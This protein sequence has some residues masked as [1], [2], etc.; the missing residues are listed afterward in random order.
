MEAPEV[1][2][3]ALSAVRSPW[4]IDIVVGVFVA[5]LNV[6]TT[7]TPDPSA[8]YY[9]YRE[10]H[11]LALVTLTV[12]A[13][14]ALI[15]RRYAP[16]TVLV[17]NLATFV[18]VTALEW[19]AGSLAVGLLVALYSVGAYSTFRRGLGSVVAVVVSLV[20]L[21]VLSRPYFDDWASLVTVFVYVA[22]WGA[23]LVVQHHRRATDEERARVIE[24]ERQRAVEAE[25]AVHSER[26]R[27]AREMHD[28]VTHT[29]SIIAVQSAVAQKFATSDPQRATE[30]M[31]AVQ[32]SSS[33]ALDDL[34]RML[35]SLRSDG[36]PAPWGPP[37]SRADLDLVVAAHRA[38]HGPV[39]LNVDPA[40]TWE[41]TTLPLTVLRIVQ[42][43]LTNVARHAP[44]ARASVDVV[45]DDDGGVVVTIVD[46]GGNGDHGTK[47]TPRRQ[48]LGLVGLRERVNA[49]GGVVDA[50]P[51][52]P[53]FR[54]RAVL[55][56]VPHP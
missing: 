43:G 33:S 29:L 32:S 44:G 31:S 28:V 23:G 7:T 13:G 56:A 11:M 9:D 6:V 51:H 27:I 40:I 24:L 36:D 54:L 48:G 46:D 16:V 39:D 41:S 55:R 17:V 22:P 20:G 45:A 10:P 18:V 12:G 35:V 26:L 34:R 52:G 30:A 21:I 25:R 2:R 15:W 3:I 38:A 53:G 14:L 8:A 1:R 19:Q 5:V 42:E 37:P 50:E 47:G 4:S 49:F